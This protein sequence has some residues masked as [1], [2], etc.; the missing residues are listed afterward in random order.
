MNLPRPLVLFLAFCGGAALFAT[1]L[2]LGAIALGAGRTAASPAAS[3]GASTSVAG[4]TAASP[5]SGAVLGTITINAVDL[6]F[7]PASVEVASA[8]RYT[9]MFMNKGKLAHDITFADG[10]KIPAAGGAMAT[11]EVVIPAGG[12]TFICSVPGHEAAGMKGGVTVAGAQASGSPA[13]GGSAAPAASIA[14]DPSAP[15]YTPRDPKAPALASG[16]VH[17]IEL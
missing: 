14:P 3:P 9:V 16:T 15:A 12:L 13:P 11:G 5:S 2:I 1:P 4:S 6:G 8:G 10:T 7:E 17:D